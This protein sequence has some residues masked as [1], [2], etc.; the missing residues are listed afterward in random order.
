M[1][2]T[3]VHADI[4]KYFDV[5]PAHYTPA[6]HEAAV[7]WIK[8]IAY[9]TLGEASD[10]LSRDVPS[11]HLACMRTLLDKTRTVRNKHVY[12]RYIT[13][14]LSLLCNTRVS[15][16]DQPNDHINTIFKFLNPSELHLVST[17]C[18]RFRKHATKQ[19]HARPLEC[20][21]AEFRVL[22]NM[23]EDL[24]SMFRLRSSVTRIVDDIRE[25]YGQVELPVSPMYTRLYGSNL[26]SYDVTHGFIQSDRFYN[27]PTSLQYLRI[28]TNANPSICLNA[29]LSQLRVLH[30][31][32]KQFDCFETLTTP[33]EELYVNTFHNTLHAINIPTSLRVFKYNHVVVSSVLQKL[34]NHV[35]RIEAGV[36]DIPTDD[37][38][39]RSR[40][41][42]IVLTREDVTVTYQRHS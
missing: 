33:L 34:M 32:C 19:I 29:V 23:L 30:V 12:R 2:V 26:R 42:F 17:T 6:E 40:S 20:M 11:R 31:E 15:L 22:S 25:K 5:I 18:K 41:R 14:D 28:E 27:A 4:R 36:V 8:R 9:T 7:T 24:A 13:R 1:L 21:H 37:E 38:F 39:V 35:D 10:I 3:R 16:H